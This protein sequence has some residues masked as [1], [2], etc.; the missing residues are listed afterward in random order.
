MAKRDPGDKMFTLG[1]LKSL[2]K[3]VITLQKE[4]KKLEAVKEKDKEKTNE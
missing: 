1:Q 4:I 3:T 2:Y